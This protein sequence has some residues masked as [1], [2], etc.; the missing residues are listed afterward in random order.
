LEAGKCTTPSRRSTA[1]QFSKIATNKCD[2]VIGF[3]FGT[4]CTKVI[5]QTP[6]FYNRWCAAVPFQQNGKGAE[7]YFEPSRVY[8][9]CPDGRVHLGS[10]QNA[11]L[12]SNIKIIFLSRIRNQVIHDCSTESIPITTN[13]FIVAYIA[14]VLQKVRLWFLE[15]HA[16]KFGDF[17]LAWHFNLGIPSGSFKT[18]K[19]IEF[20]RIAQASWNLS[21]NK[22][23]INL[24][25]AFKELEE[26]NANQI[27]AS[28]GTG[29]ISIVPEITAEG[30]AYSRSRQRSDGLHLIIDIGAS[31]LDLAAFTLFKRDGIDRHSQLQTDVRLLGSFMLHEERVKAVWS[32]TQKYLKDGYRKLSIMDRIPEEMKIYWPS[33][34][35]PSDINLAIY[36][37]CFNVIFSLI[38]NLKTKRDINSD[39]WDK[40][41]PVFLCGGGRN[42]PF[43]KRVMRDVNVRFILECG[44]AE[45]QFKDL[46]KPE[47]LLIDDFYRFAVAYGLSF[48]SFEIGVIKPS[49]KIQNIKRRFSDKYENVSFI[50]KEQE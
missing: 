12:Y 37:K 34:D 44:C 25:D 50:G 28:T 36:D 2:V 19:I 42:I 47:N 8:F 41:L 46:P 18:D 10:F 21:T 27:E 7:K 17:N 29:E 32:H 48:F 24:R 45:L 14:C 33:Q 5:L 26:I 20:L 38:H 22:E 11:R 30:I 4:S 16:E 13:E 40:G 39:A 23:E 6:S 43:Y 49:A 35:L 9:S 1:T 31:T 3:D 15:N